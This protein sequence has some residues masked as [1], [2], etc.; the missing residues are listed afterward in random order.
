MEFRPLHSPEDLASEY[1]SGWRYGV[2]AGG[3][4][5]LLFTLIPLLAIFLELICP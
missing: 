5:V 4:A 1:N 2:A 3:A